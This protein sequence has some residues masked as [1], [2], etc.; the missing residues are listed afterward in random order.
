MVIKKIKLLQR[1]YSLAGRI[2][3]ALER[4]SKFKPESYVKT[5]FV[6]IG[7]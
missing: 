2:G 4:I 1:T 6:R 5:T 7:Y 3:Q